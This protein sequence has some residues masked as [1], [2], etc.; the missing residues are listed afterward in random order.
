MPAS[1][2]QALGQRL[3][4][5]GF[6]IVMILCDAALLLLL[7][8]ITTV[9]GLLLAAAAV[10]GMIAQAEWLLAFLFLG[11]SLLWPLDLEPEL[12]NALLIGARVLLLPAWWVSLHRAAREDVSLA[13][14]VPGEDLRHERHSAGARQ[15]FTHALRSPA[16]LLMLALALLVWV[17]LAV[18]PAPLYGSGKMRS[19][20]LANV[21]YFL[22]PVLLWPL[23]LQARNVDRLLRAM[24]VL[25]GLFVAA[26]LLHVAG[27]AGSFGWGA[28]SADPVTGVPGRLGW[29]GVDPIWTG[30]ALA[31]W[32]VLLAWAVGRRQLSAPVAIALGLPAFWLLLRTGSRGPLAALLLSP[33]AFFLLPRPAGQRRSRALGTLAAVLAA[34]ALAAGAAALLLPETERERLAAILLRSPLGAVVG[35]GGGESGAFAEGLLRDP[36]AIYRRVVLERG[37]SLIGEAL[38]WGAGTGAFPALLFLRDFRLYPH[39]I[40]AELLI[41]QGPLG[42]LL[43]L[44]FLIVLWRCARRLAARDPSHGWL[45]VL[46]AMALLNAQVS[47]DLSANAAIWF[48]GGLVTGL[49]CAA[50]WRGGREAPRQG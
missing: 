6:W 45:A 30:R 16:T 10:A 47:G 3:Q 36:S 17:M 28:G 50:G 31:I 9:A 49:A 4:P 20:F 41:E 34:L 39:N 37:F 21:A 32:I 22:G 19:F 2:T 29:F 44:L 25:G 40:E 8:R 24:L 13:Q 7:G 48:W 5:R 1:A 42:L 33:F 35:T 38:P 46:L 11:M 26:G 23:W 27:W 12:A 14:P 15:V 18:S 43:F